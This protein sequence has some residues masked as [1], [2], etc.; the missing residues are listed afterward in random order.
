MQKMKFAGIL[1]AVGLTAVAQATV[2]VDLSKEVGRIKPM[3]GVGNGPVLGRPDGQSSERMG[4]GALFKE[5]EIPFCR[6]HDS[7]SCMIYGSPY[8]VD[9]T[10]IF[11]DFKSDENDP[12]NYRF[13]C[14]DAF[15]D[16]MRKVGSKP[17][18]R[19]GQTFNFTV[20]KSSVQPPED[21]GKWARIC[22]HIVRHYNDGWADGFKWNIEYWE[23]W[24]EPD[25]FADP[26]TSSTWGGTGE[27]FDRLYEVT[28]KHLK[29][30]HPSIKVG[31]PALAWKEEWGARFLDHQKTVGSPLDFF[32]WHIY[33][34]EVRRIAELCA[35]YRRMLD[36]R[37]FVKTES[38]LNEWNYNRTFG[39]GFVV[40]THQ[41][42]AGK[43]AAFA[44][45]TMSACQS[46]PVDMLM[47]YDARPVSWNGIFD[48]TDA[49]K[50]YWAFW[51]WKELVRRGTSVGCATD[52]R[53]IFVA[54]ARDV[55]GK[56]GILVTRFN[57]DD[58]IIDERIVGIRLRGGTWNGVRAYLTDE[59][60]MNCSPCPVEISG[61][62]L[63]VE[64][65]P[66]SFVF[67]ENHVE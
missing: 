51:A 13:K 30:K 12:S 63:K 18:F 32:S 42:K 26:K 43:G 31:G 34:H 9:I 7:N 17:F 24:N 10:A 4:N 64:L 41:R 33:T 1:L 52:E 2:T 36:E 48:G 27:Q 39:P 28:A 40:S 29:E 66:R 47:Y 57:D 21:F 5:L 59:R 65:L 55:K 20:D 16:N 54:A 25:C 44:A 15:L 56:F 53:D 49:L 35:S 62:E 46:M 45:A 19:L 61:D 37:G 22:E 50:T 11:P 6:T 3:N 58:N 67:I 8:I 60:M 14:T 38:I 23:I